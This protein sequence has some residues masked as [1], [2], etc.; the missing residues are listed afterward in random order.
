MPSS[1]SAGPQR[2]RTASCRSP[3]RPKPT[4]RGVQPP[5]RTDPRLP[6]SSGSHAGRGGGRASPATSRR[7]I[8]GAC[9]GGRLG[10]GAKI[11]QEQLPAVTVRLTRGRL[12]WINGCCNR[13]HTLASRILMRYQSEHAPVSGTGGLPQQASDAS[14]QDFKD[15]TSERAAVFQPIQKLALQGEPLPSRAP[16]PAKTTPKLRGSP[17]ASSAASKSEG[18]RSRLLRGPGNPLPP[19]LGRSSETSERGGG[20]IK[21]GV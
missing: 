2:V 16:S 10:D 17:R 15:V 6:R 5:R 20:G 14:R 3:P 12:R 1:A 11:L 8:S 9:F 19:A 21:S 4:G 7:D 13:H 18:E